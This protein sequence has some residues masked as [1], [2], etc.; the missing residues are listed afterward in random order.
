MAIGHTSTYTIKMYC[1]YDFIDIL[2]FS[3]TK[4]LMHNANII[5][6]CKGARKKIIIA[7]ARK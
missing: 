2:N 3:W 4:L 5:H 7:Y 6:K 1:W